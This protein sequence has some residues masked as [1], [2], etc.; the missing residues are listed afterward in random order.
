MGGF[1]IEFEQGRPVLS[2]CTLKNTGL[3]LRK[4]IIYEIT[5]SVCKNI[6]IGNRFRFLYTRI[7]E[8]LTNNS[9][10]V[11]KHLRSCNTTNISVKIL[12]ET[13]ATSEYE[14]H[15]T[16]KNWNLRS[17]IKTSKIPSLNFLMYNFSVFFPM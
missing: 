4:N 15:F 1:L 10:S 8:H 16:S 6:Y 12:T 14:R 9:S 17:T 5:C 2:G 13:V 3:C 11:F 7:K